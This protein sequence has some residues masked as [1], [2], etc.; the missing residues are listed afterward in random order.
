MLTNYFRGSIQTPLLERA[1]TIQGGFT[2]TP[3]IMPRPGTPDEVA[4]MVVFLLSDAAMFTTGT[5]Y[6]VDGGWDP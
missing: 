6:S 3:T 4:H 2:P 1:N 5:V